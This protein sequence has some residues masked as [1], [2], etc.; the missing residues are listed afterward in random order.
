MSSEKTQK[1]LSVLLSIHFA[2]SGEANNS[3]A[4]ERKGKIAKM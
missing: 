2:Q 4:Q 1:K 3:Q